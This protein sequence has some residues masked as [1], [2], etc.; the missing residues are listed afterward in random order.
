MGIGRHRG[1]LLAVLVSVTSIATR[2]L[3]YFAVA[4]DRFHLPAF[5]GHVYVAMAEKPGF[6]TVAPWGYRVLHPWLIRA[7]TLPFRDLVPAFFWSTV[8][9]LTAGGVLLFLYLRRLGHG[10]LPALLGV[11]LY[12][13]SGPVGEVVR[14]QFL[15]EPLT[16]VLEMA[17]LLA[18]ESAAALPLVAAFAVLG[19]LSKEF[20]LLLLPLVYLVRRERLGDRKALRDAVLVALPAILVCVALRGYWTPHIH[21]PLP[22]LEPATLALAAERFRE[23]FPA[24]RGAALLMGLTPLAVL[25]AFRAAGRR[26]VPRGSYLFL[27]TLASPFVNPVTFL[28]LDVDRLLLYAIPAVLPLA[29]VVFDRVYPHVKAPA[30]PSP[31]ESWGLRLGVG[32]TAAS[33]IVP[34]LVVDR[35]RR[36]DLQGTH[37]ATVMLAIL[38]GS[39][40]AAADLEAGEEFAFDPSAGRYS[41][42]LSK[43]FNLSQLRHVRWFLWDGW[44]PSA[45]RTAGDVVMAGRE[46]TLLLPCFRPRDLELTLSL[47]APRDERLAVRVNQRPVGDVLATP[48]SRET[49]VRIPEA[50]LFRG[51][52]ALTLAT[53]ESEAPRVRLRRFAIRGS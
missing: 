48:G 13:V 6:F 7:A 5:D 39:L 19:V 26:L 49:V 27:A 51:D 46:A 53:L 31:S 52:N 23:S 16:F 8:L 40:D 32:L 2:E 4:Y 37:D 34:F 18:L 41:R 9:G 42:G 10:E 33:L 22:A 15:A 35:Y 14:Y 45:P 25:G 47:D 30:A 21:P 29:L 36:V 17:F 28:S 11:T 43:P 24:W 38:R 44:G 20:F 50:V 1:L 12:G 3:E